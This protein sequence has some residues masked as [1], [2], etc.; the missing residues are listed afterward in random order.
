[1]RNE[2]CQMI[3]GQYPGTILTL[4]PAGWLRQ[5]EPVTGVIFEH[6]FNAVGSFGWF[7]NELH[8]L[9]FQL[10]ISSTAIVSIEHARAEH[11]LVHDRAQLLRRLFIHKHAGLWFHQD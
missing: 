2:K 8:A 3:N 1:M 6:C 4:I 7:G 5:T 11:A 10:L 9:R